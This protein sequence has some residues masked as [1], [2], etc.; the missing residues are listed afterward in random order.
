MEKKAVC[1]ILGRINQ[2]DLFRN[3]R[4]QMAFSTPNKVYV[5]DRLGRDVGAFL[6]FK[7]KITQAVSVFDYD[8][9]K[10]TVFGHP[11]RIAFDV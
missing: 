6:N 11:K 2:V 4:L 10:D 7:D 8:K 9:I 3:G 5:L 1:A